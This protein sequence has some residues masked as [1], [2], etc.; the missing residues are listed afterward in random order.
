MDLK[1]EIFGVR[2]ELST[3]QRDVFHDEVAVFIDKKEI[4]VK[5]DCLG[6]FNSMEKFAVQG[7]SPYFLKPSGLVGISGPSSARDFLIKINSRG[8]LSEVLVPESEILFWNC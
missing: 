8:Y 6:F 1:E 2:C 3:S 4:V 5:K 7:I